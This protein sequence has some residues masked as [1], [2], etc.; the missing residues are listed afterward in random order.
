MANQGGPPIPPFGLPVGLPGAPPSFMPPGLPTGLPTGYP[1]FLPGAPPPQ[2]PLS[3]PTSGS[4]N[5]SR[6]SRPRNP[7]PPRSRDHHESRDPIRHHRVPPPESRDSRNV[8][9]TPPRDYPTQIER[10]VIDYSG[11]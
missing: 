3:S 7:S 10:K 1:P 11:A 2:I 9:R 4:V 6:E 5:N 8:P